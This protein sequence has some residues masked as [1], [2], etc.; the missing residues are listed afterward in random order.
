MLQ[1]DCVYASRLFAVVEREAEYCACFEQFLCLENREQGLG[2]VRITTDLFQGFAH[3]LGPD[4]R[5][6]GKLDRRLSI[7][8]TRDDADLIRTVLLNGR[9]DLS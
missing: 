5:R 8:R 4:R 3:Q 2:C 7:R 9:G 1:T 6:L